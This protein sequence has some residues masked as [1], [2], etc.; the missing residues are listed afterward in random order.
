MT[1]DSELKRFMEAQQR[2]YETALAEIKNG[3]KSSHWMWYIFPQIR[4]LGFSSVSRHY[5]ISGLKEAEAFL[6]HPML[7]PRL[8]AICQAL[9]DLAGSNATQIFGSP[10]DLK[11]CS[12]MTLF[13]AVKDS[14]PVF[15]QVLDRFFRG[16][17]DPQ[18]LTI[19]NR[20]H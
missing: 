17:P 2:D 9:L 13:A 7:G 8:T 5:G 12:S 1:A 18:T 16:K 20:S 4:G 15:Q 19:L 11:L 10:D 3:R 6:R 14:D